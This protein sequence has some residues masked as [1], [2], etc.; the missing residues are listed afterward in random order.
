MFSNYKRVFWLALVM[1]LFMYVPFW[2]TGYS[3]DVWM[4]LAR[5]REWIADGFP[6]REHLMMTQ[7]FPMGVEMHWT[8]PMDIIGYVFAWPFIPQWGVQEALEIMANFVPMLGMLL[9]VGGFFF[10]LK[11]YVS[12]KI[13][14]VAFWLFFYG[15]GTCWSYSTLGYFD[16]HVFHFG[17]LVWSIALVARGCLFPKNVGYFI[18]AGIVSACGTW[19]TSEFFINT[20][21]LV[22]PFVFAW[23]TDNKSLKPAII[24]TAAYTVFL[25]AV[26]TFDHPIDGFWTLDFYRVSL[27]HVILGALNIVVFG[28]LSAKWV[29]ANTLRRWIYGSLMG[30]GLGCVLLFGFTDKLLIP[31]VDPVMY[32][33]WTGKVGEMQPLYNRY[34]AFVAECVM[35]F[36]LGIVM[37][38]YAVRHR[39]QKITPLILMTGVGVLFY[40]PILAMHL[41]VGIS[42]NAFLIFLGAGVLALTFFPRE[43]SFRRSLLF[44]IFYLIFIGVQLRG[45]SILERIRIWGVERYMT[46]YRNDQNIYVPEIL[47]EAFEKRLEE[48]KAENEPVNKNANK[49][50]AKNKN[51]HEEDEN[52]AC[53]IN[54]KV[55]E[56]IKKDSQNGAVFTDI[57]DAPEILWKTGKPVLGGPYHTNIEGLTDL[58]MIEYDV[59]PFKRAHAMMKKHRV[60]QLYIPNPACDEF[61]FFDDAKKKMREPRDRTFRHAVYYQTKD[62][63]KWLKLEY[64]DPKTRIKIFRVI[65]EK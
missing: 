6:W 4:R 53:K 31:M 56:I 22:L 8:R 61:L 47:K 13:T 12:P 36:I 18:A 54:D 55:I 11:G 45:N 21:I 50:A 48:E 58:F 57:Y 29:R 42:Q 30:L 46:L 43:K 34:A 1:S 44:V 63:P 14:F 15:L 24:Y 2:V 59:P 26:M 60:T 9:A 16:H 3:T 23:L 41:R 33:L 52:Y 62:S 17:C 7:N 35:P 51:K 5:I 10:G 38:L 37:V 39:H 27:F 65:E 20:Y 40:V 49:T 32:H 64:D 19:L 28:V 25:G